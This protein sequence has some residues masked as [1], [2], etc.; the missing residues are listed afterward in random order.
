MDDVFYLE[1]NGEVELEELKTQPMEFIQ[2][3][4]AKAE[5]YI[6]NVHDVRQIAIEQ[7]LTDEQFYMVLAYRL[8]VDMTRGAA[9]AQAAAAAHAADPRIVDTEGVLIKPNLDIP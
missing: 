6:P 2:G 1:P 7:D 3:K 4:L 5:V 9:Q 8:L